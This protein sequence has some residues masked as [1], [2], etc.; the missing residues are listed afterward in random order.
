MSG[1][2]ALWLNAPRLMRTEDGY[3]NVRLV[4]A[5]DAVIFIDSI[6]RATH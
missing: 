3:V 1:P 2:A 6:H 4:S 5:Y